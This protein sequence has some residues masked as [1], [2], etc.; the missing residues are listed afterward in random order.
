MAVLCNISCISFT[1]EI[2]ITYDKVKIDFYISKVD[3]PDKD[4]TYHPLMAE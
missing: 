2:E 1:N 4:L 3:F